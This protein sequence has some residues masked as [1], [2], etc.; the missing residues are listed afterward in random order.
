MLYFMATKTIRVSEGTWRILR[1]RA[2]EKEITIT[3]LVEKWAYKMWN[4]E[5]RNLK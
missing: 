4:S 1:K 2:F 3:K 5:D